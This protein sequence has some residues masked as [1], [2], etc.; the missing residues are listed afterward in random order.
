MLS[1]GKSTSDLTGSQAQ[2]QA[3]SGSLFT[4]G[5]LDLTDLDQAP[6]AQPVHLDEVSD[7]RVQVSVQTIAV[8]WPP[9][10]GNRGHAAFDN[11][12]A[13][14]M[15]KVMLAPVPDIKLPGMDDVGSTTGH[16]T[17]PAVTAAAPVLSAADPASA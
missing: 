4:F 9:V 7:V 6:E 15:G 17:L 11:N 10:P 3:A 13:E 8:T 16:A 1:P 14:S 2:S 12:S 5:T